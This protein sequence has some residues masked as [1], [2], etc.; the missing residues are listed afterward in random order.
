MAVRYFSLI[1]L[2]TRLNLHAED[3]GHTD[4]YRPNSG[5]AIHSENTR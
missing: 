5:V 2:K 3:Q 1:R 4:I